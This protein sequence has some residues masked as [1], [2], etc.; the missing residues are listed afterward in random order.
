MQKRNRMMMTALVATLALAACYSQGQS[1]TLRDRLKARR[2]AAQSGQAS[3]DGTSI[4]I[5]SG[6]QQ[7]TFLVHVPA[8]VPANPGVVL[9]FHGGSV[10]SAGTLQGNIGLDAVADRDG[11]ITV[12]PETLGKN[13]TD[14]RVA[15]QGGPNDVQFTRDI[16]AYM[17]KTYGVSASKIFATGI[18]NG[19]IFDYKLAC[20]AP[21]L[22]R[23]IAPVAAN[24]ADQLHA[25]CGAPKP[26]PLMMFMGVDDPLMPY[27][28]GYPKLK[29][30][31]EKVQGPLTDQMMSSVDTAA[32]WAGVNGCGGSSS[33][34]LPDAVSDG[35]TV[36]EMDFA[37]CNRGSV[38]LFSIN[39]G[40]HAWPGTGKSGGKLTGKNTN[41][42]S[43]NEEMV[44]FFKQYGL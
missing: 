15:T 20:D 13:W 11:F 35:T 37:S 41:D 44:A 31:L 28:G 12:Y 17:Q 27:D 40:G 18:S 1:E 10:G 6:G 26:M 2:A 8:N 7:R 32:F 21:G 14:G 3:G 9:V 43:A 33:K 5:T 38:V 23:A 39:G 25:D 42:I 4:A 16:V 30:M 24:M 34:N 29:A 36:T 22:L 19:G